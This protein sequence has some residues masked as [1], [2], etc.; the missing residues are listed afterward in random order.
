[1]WAVVWLIA[2]KLHSHPPGDFNPYPLIKCENQKR[3]NT[4]HTHSHTLTHTHTHAHAHA[5][6]H[7]LTRKNL[8]PGTTACHR[9]VRD[10]ATRVPRHAHMHMQIHVVPACACTYRYGMCTSP[11]EL[12]LRCVGL[13]P[14]AHPWRNSAGTPL[15][16]T[17]RSR[18]V[19]GAASA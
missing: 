2:A 10:L 1:M 12:C 13:L 15:A 16:I 3:I 18:W 9:Q 14:R 11:P 4:A 5:H 6:A 17:Q 19:E 7:A 8:L